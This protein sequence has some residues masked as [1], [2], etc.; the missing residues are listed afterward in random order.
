[1]ATSIGN[2]NTNIT[3]NANAITSING[4]I[5]GGAFASAGTSATL[6]T[7]IAGVSATMATSISNY[8]PLAGGTVTGNISVTGDLT[9]DTNT[10]YVDSTNNR[11]GIGTTSP[12]YQI[13]IQGSSNNALR[14]KTSSPVL[15]LEDS[16]DNAHHTFI[17]SSDDLYITSDAGNTGNGNMIFR[18]G[19]SSERMRLD[20]NGNMGLGVS[21]PSTYWGSGDN[22][23]LFTGL[24]FL[25]SNG[26][27]AVSLYSN[28]YRN[29]SSGFTY[30]GIN[31]NTTTASGIDL[32]PNGLIKFRNGT[33]SG[34]ALPE[35]MRLETDGDL[36]V[37]GNVIA[38]STTISDK[39]LKKDIA[40]IDNALWKVSQLNGC[41]FT[42]LKD[43]R[44]SAG[45]I[46]QDLEKVLPSAVIED[47]A[48]FHG[49]EGE[50]YKTVQYDQVI[51]LLVEAVKELTAKVEE[52]ENAS[53]K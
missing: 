10:L 37:D 45:L 49:E 17:G 6:E 4:V 16:D 43:D 3:T 31:G 38:Y 35:K 7:R 42:Y 20:S 29:S 12:A 39:R 44:K 30:L 28:G 18:N 27:F 26:N 21:P 2:S 40:P 41:T 9:V 24:G 36:H 53:T 51:G 22:A 52:L 14:L 25:G 48:V 46:A 5:A 1:M 13:D 8:L 19:G 47:E 23:A 34:T 50:T 32:E 11:V 33:A 15:R